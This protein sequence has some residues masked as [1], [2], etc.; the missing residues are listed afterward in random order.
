MKEQFFMVGEAAKRLGISVR[1]LQYYDK[2]G[3]ISPSNHSEGGRRLYSDRDIVR[4]NQII[5][6]KYLGFSLEEIK[7]KLLPLDSPQ[8]VVKILEIQENQVS[9]KIKTLTEIHKSLSLLKEEISDMNTVN[10]NKYAEIIELLR[11]QDEN[12]WIIKLFEEKTISAAATKYNQE[13]AKAFIANLERVWDSIIIFI[14]S[15]IDESSEKAQ[16]LAKEWWDMVNE[17]TGGDMTVFQDIEK[18]GEQSQN[19]KNQSWKEK[20]SKTQGYLAKALGIYFENNN[21]EVPV[22][23]DSVKH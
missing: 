9:E 10:W 16:T 15:G 2:L 8:E 11:R 19:W 14:D 12:Y 22:N 3:L 7:E 13:T 18:F 1:T 21:I 23:H 6:L 20:W 5:S 4:L 17:F